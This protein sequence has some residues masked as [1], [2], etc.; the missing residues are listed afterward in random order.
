MRSLGEESDSVV[1][2]EDSDNVIDIL[3]RGTKGDT[4]VVRKE[5]CCR[6]DWGKVSLILGFRNGTSSSSGV[7]LTGDERRHGRRERL[8]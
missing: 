1:V 3:S 5:T 4:G 6:W 7:H 2:R 8:D